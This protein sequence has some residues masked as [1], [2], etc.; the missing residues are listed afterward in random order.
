MATKQFSDKH[1]RYIFDEMLVRRRMTCEAIAA[2]YEQDALKTLSAA[3]R[4]GYIA[5]NEEARPGSTRRRLRWG[6]SQE[7]VRSE[8][9]DLQ[10]DWKKALYLATYFDEVCRQAGYSEESMEGLRRPKSSASEEGT[11]QQ[12][13]RRCSRRHLN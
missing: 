4:L 8:K 5:V 2:Y 11:E 9:G 12:I 3:Q 10:D 1:W 7:G 13:Q 6:N